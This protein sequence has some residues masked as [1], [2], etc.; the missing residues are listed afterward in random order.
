MKL[1]DNNGHRLYLNKSEREAFRVAAQKAPLDLRTFCL[2]L[3]YTGCRISEAL[4]IT[5]D[6]IDFADEGFTFESL[7]KRKKGI[8]RFVPV[9]STFLDTLNLVHEL[10]E[11]KQKKRYL[12]HWSRTTAWRRVKAIMDVADIG[13]N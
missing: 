4:Q 9:P 5:A 2:L 1:Y 7:K 8:Y 6:R 11:R 10:Q 13:S 3:Y 12:W